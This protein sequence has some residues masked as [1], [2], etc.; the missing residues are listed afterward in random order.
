MNL[1]DKAL[2]KIIVGRLPFTAASMSAK[3]DT[4]SPYGGGTGVLGEPDVTNFRNDSE[5]CFQNGWGI[6]VIRSYATPIA[7][8][9]KD[10]EGHVFWRQVNN[11]FSKTTS[12]HQGIIREALTIEW[13]AA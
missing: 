11:K 12:R 6:Y 3:Y 2:H 10:S 7:W 9:Y 13:S 4:P 1:N 5:A 8:A